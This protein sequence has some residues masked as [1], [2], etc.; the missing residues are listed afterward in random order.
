MN[1]ALTTS[2]VLLL[3][4]WGQCCSHGG[5]NQKETTGRV[6]DRALSS[7]VVLILKEVGWP[8]DTTYGNYNYVPLLAYY[9]LQ[10]SFKF[11]FKLFIFYFY[12]INM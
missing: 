6:D 7:T 11:C 4:T 2:I 1:A 3:V 8:I 10:I 12:L 9:F 5:K